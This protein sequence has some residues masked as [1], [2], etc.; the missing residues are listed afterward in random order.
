MTIAGVQQS[1]DLAWAIPAV[2]VEGEQAAV[3][4]A[5]V[6]GQALQLP[7]PV[8]PDDA[9]AT[10]ELVDGGNESG[11]HAVRIKVVGARGFVQELH[12]QPVRTLL[13]VGI[14]IDCDGSCLSYR[15]RKEIGKEDHR[16]RSHVAQG[17]QYLQRVHLLKVFREGSQLIDDDRV[18][19][20]E[21]KGARDGI[22]QGLGESQFDPEIAVVG[23]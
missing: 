2:R 12:G 18:V 11:R 20:F 19:Q 15:V 5:D 21:I 1:D 14:G 8:V 23:L 13:R 3:L 9:V 22:R 10:Y 17:A 16:E 4:A 7:P 6:A